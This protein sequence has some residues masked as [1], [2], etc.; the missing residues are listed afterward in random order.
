M[1]QSFKDARIFLIESNIS[2]IRFWSWLIIPVS[3]Q[4]LP[5]TPLIQQPMPSFYSLENKS[6]QHKAKNREL[7][8]K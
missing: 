3:S 4:I 7:K 6:E 5:T 1:L 8:T 2:Y